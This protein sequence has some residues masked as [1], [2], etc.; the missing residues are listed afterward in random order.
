MATTAVMQQP[1]NNN[2]VTLAETNERA[3][4][5]LFAVLALRFCG[6][7]GIK[8]LHQCQHRSIRSI[9]RGIG[10]IGSIGSLSRRIKKA[11]PALTGSV[12]AGLGC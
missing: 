7:A 12:L 9:N 1:I 8:A 11:L 3:I 10:I 4:N 5:T 6:Q 2:S